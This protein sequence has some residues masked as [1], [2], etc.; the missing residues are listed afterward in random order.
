VMPIVT[1]KQDSQSLAIR[2]TRVSGRGNCF[3]SNAAE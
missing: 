2:I 1:K 3:N